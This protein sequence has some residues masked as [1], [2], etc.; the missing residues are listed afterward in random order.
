MVLI[1]VLDP[2]F[3]PLK[4]IDEEKMEDLNVELIDR[5][6]LL[7]QQSHTE[8]P[9]PKK[10]KTALDISLGEEESDASTL[11]QGPSDE[12]DQCLSEK[13]ISKE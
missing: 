9:P 12:I 6:N 5:M 7:P 4:F 3:K 13:P 1:A 11:P 2:R 8:R 10:S